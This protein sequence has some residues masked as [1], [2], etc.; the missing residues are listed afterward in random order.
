MAEKPADDKSKKGGGGV[1]K[2]A[3]FAVGGLL[4]VGI[5]LGAGYFIFSGSEPPPA[6][7]LLGPDG[8]PVPAATAPVEPEI[9]PNVELDANG[10][11]IPKKMVKETPVQET[12]VTTYYEFAGT[13]TTNL[14]GSRKMAQL[15][16]GVSTQYDESIMT[17]VDTHQLALRS[18]VLAA[19]SEFSEE[20][21][22]GKTGRD[23]LAKSIQNALNEK[24]VELEG[25]GGIEHVH[26]TSFIIQ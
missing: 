24:L 4:L 10:N 12:Y 25:F 2:I 9:D 18:E 22:A 8:L 21:V 16:I 7:Q 15:G 17:N 6:E 26:F 23:N 19:I 1:V 13:F 14:R 5:G 11:P 20:D 3:I